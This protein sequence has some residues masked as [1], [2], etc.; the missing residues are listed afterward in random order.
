MKKNLQET[1][2]LLDS[3]PCRTGVRV[4]GLVGAGARQAVQLPQLG[5]GPSGTCSL[6]LRTSETVFCSLPPTSLPPCLPHAFPFSSRK[7]WHLAQAKPSPQKVALSKA[8]PRTQ[9]GSVSGFVAAGKAS[10]ARCQRRPSG[11]GL[12]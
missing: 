4:G 12:P 8:C 7:A 3:A 10:A 1:L 5:P 11:T 2:V 6:P 9:G